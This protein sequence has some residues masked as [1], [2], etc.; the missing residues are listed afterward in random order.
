MSDFL[1]INWDG[2]KNVVS[3]ASSIFTDI[4]TISQS[5]KG[6]NVNITPSFGVSVDKANVQVSASE[7]IKGLLPYIVLG[8]IAIIGVVLMFRRK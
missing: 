7:V 3:D 2:V 4:N 6:S 5:L 8:I 1:G